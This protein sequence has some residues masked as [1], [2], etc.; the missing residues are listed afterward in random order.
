[1]EIN[2][3]MHQFVA[4]RDSGTKVRTGLGLVVGFVTGHAYGIR[5]KVLSLGCQKIEVVSLDDCMF[6]PK[7]D[8]ITPATLLKL[9]AWQEQFGQGVV[10]EAKRPRHMMEV[11]LQNQAGL[12]SDWFMLDDVTIL[13]SR[14]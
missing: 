7:S 10:A 9:H 1:V 12:S 2:N 13:G 14:P 6:V 4:I 3:I 11:R 5:V 8:I